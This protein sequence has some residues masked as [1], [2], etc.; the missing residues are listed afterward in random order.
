M[1]AFLMRG[2]HPMT[3]KLAQATLYLLYLLLAVSALLVAAE[4][5]CRW[6]VPHWLPFQEDRSIV[7]R[8]D[9]DFG[10]S[11]RPNLKEA[12]VRYPQFQIQVSTNTM[13]L[14]DQEYPLERT[15]KKRMLV[16]G[17]SF[18]WGFGVQGPER[19]TEILEQ[20]HP[21]W[22]IINAGTSGYGTDQEY[23][24]YLKKGQAFKA[25]VVV[26]LLYYNDFE[27]NFRREQY[28][29]S[30]PYFTLDDKG[31]LQVHNQPVPAATLSQRLNH[32]IETQTVMI[33]RLVGLGVLIQHAVM[34]P[35]MNEG[36]LRYTGGFT[37]FRDSHEITDALLRALK[38]AVEANGSQFVVFASPI[39]PGLKRNLEELTQDGSWNYLNLD[40]YI[41]GKE[42]QL[43]IPGDEHWNAAGHGLV[44]DVM[45]NYLREKKIF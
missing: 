29:Y 27:N 21:D 40:P 31:Q 42:A 6:L 36:D 35:F 14:R 20:R 18:V 38:T 45:E 26:L 22:E 39:R 3:K 41:D 33:R 34:K 5:L 24:Y 17:D 13:G 12:L 2:R 9:P 11:Q 1:T 7:W 23:L 44:A 30:K 37:Q 25:D 19:F 8:Y 15:G 16:L 28:F 10:W 32:H 4:Y 43:L